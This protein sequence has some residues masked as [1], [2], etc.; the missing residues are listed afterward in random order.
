MSA[1]TFGEWLKQRRK[2]LDL[3]QDELARQV[4]C[5]TSMLQKIEAGDR[6]PSAQMAESLARKLGVASDQHAAFV[7]FARAGQRATVGAPFHSPSNLP[8]PTTPLI[9]RAHDVAAVCRRLMRDDT[10]LLTLVGPPGIGKTRLALQVAAEARDRFDD[11][12]FFVA[13]A[14]ITDP[15][16]VAP[17]IIQTLGLKES[18]RQ[19]PVDHLSEYLRD[20]LT[21]LVLD[22]LEQVVTAAPMVARLLAACPLLKIMATSRVALRVRAERQFHVPPLGLPD[23]TRLPPPQELAQY[24]ALALFVERAQAVQPDFDLT[25]A[26]AAAVARLCHRLDGLPLAIELIAARVRLLSPAEILRRLGGRF[27]LQSDGLR[28]IDERQ[29]TLKN[30]I[31][32][33]YDLLTQEEQIL[34]ARLAVFVGGWTLDAAESVCGNGASGLTAPALDL[35]ASLVNKSLVAQREVNDESRF[36]MLETI[37]EYTLEKLEASGEAEAVRRRHTE[38]YLAMMVKVGPDLDASSDLL[39]RVEREHDN[40]RAAL[41]WSLDR[42]EV[43]MAARLSLTIFPLWS[44]RAHHL[45]EGRQ[46]FR[47]VLA[48]ARDYPLPAC[49]PAKVVYSAG[50]LAYLQSDQAAARPLLEE[51]LALAR[52]SKDRRTI[53]HALHGL[54]NVAMN[55]GQYGRVSALLNECLPLA[56]Q[57]GDK[58]LIAMSLNNLAEVARLQ[59]DY[60]QA[61]PMFE[62]GAQLLAEMGSK[63]FMAILMDGLGTIMQYQ[64]R[65]D[66]ALAIHMQCLTLAHEMD[67][68]R[69]IA[70]SLEKLAGV[71]AGTGSAERA[72]RLLGAAEALREAIHVPVESI[73]RPD[74]ERFLSATRV[75]LD[76]KSS[77]AAW[78]EGRAMTLEQAIACALNGALQLAGAAT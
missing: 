34:F 60:E 57:M 31:E 63:S 10:R 76:K 33:S 53:A 32:W 47:Q 78:A 58:W 5:A 69:I 12:A 46:W 26:N 71:A 7:E 6:R 67:D 49:V 4:G 37:R 2:A 22:N 44:M 50:I 17:T 41:Q 3:T 14:S 43:E 54:S 23:P 61:L 35:L 56:R 52:E 20:R 42:G 38:Y 15:D 77:S 72:A 13:L 19:S 64:G 66:R 9:G 74:Y 28:D 25:E 73:D 27:L 21:L 40:L 59:G 55:D 16:L 70:L 45:T 36:T 8:A 18:G 68:Q 24:P 75:G 11:G 65:Y 30:A 29:R 39:D 62:E 1:D 48:A 51:A